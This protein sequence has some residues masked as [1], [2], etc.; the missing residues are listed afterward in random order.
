MHSDGL[1]MRTDPSPHR[2]VWTHPEGVGWPASWGA[3]RGGPPGGPAPGRARGGPPRAGGPPAGGP[4]RGAPKRGSWDPPGRAQN[5]P[6]GGASP[7]VFALEGG[8]SRPCKGPRIEG[9]WGAPLGGP[10]GGP[11]VYIF[12]G[13]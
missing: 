7:Y 2:Q 6:S 12:E 9:P 10:P 8:V 4:P 3:P 5:G 13:I 1:R 11:R